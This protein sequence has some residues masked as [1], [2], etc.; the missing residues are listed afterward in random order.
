MGVP[1]GEPVGVCFVVDVGE[2]ADVGEEGVVG[3]EGGAEVIHCGIWMGLGL[4]RVDLPEGS[5]E[6]VCS[7]YQ[8]V[9]K[10]ILGQSK[11]LAKSEACL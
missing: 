10:G 7:T 1:G 6:G 5:W 11:S 3:G 8:Q 2:G 4:L 9:H